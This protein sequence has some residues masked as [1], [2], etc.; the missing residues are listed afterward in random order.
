MN[1]LKIILCSMLAL[2]VIGLASPDLA[3]AN[4]F[5]IRKGKDLKVSIPKDHLL[6][7]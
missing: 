2:P 6:K 7:C 3:A 1:R 4:D 5:E